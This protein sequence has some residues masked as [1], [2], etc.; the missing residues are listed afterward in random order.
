[1][2][3]IVITGA[4]L[5][6]PL[7][8]SLAEAREVFAQSRSVIS[9]SPISSPERPRVAAWVDADISVGLP[10]SLVKTADRAA[11]MALQASDRAVA[12]AGLTP[13]SFDA[14]RAGVFLGSAIG[15]IHSV[16]HAEEALFRRG[17][18]PAL[19][20]LK[21][22]PNGAASCVSM[23]HGFKGE[24]TTFA[25]ACAS[26]TTAFGAALRQLRLGELDVA[27]VGGAEAPLVE[28]CVLAWENL[29]MIARQDIE[30][31]ET[32]FR[33][34][35]ADRTGVV[36]GEGAAMYVLE[37]EEHARARGARILGVLQGFGASADAAHITAP[38]QEG[39]ALAM[40]KALQ[41]AGLGPSDIGYI[42]AHGTG[43][44]LG[45]ATETRSVIDVFGDHAQRV[46]MS[47]TKSA[48]GHLKGA[49]GAVE[50]AA[51]LVALND[52]IL[53]P[54]LN[55]N[56]ADPEC[57][58]DYVPNVARTGVRVDAVMSNAFAFGGS[59]CSMVVT[60]Y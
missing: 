42:N 24:C 30:H 41:N 20:L 53:P 37:T 27:L 56:E 44:K 17:N 22:L 46:P 6:S 45:D 19:T 34:F 50:L 9:V 32:C 59:N 14:T 49:S 52:G 25:V 18:M 43:T 54:T 1:M 39:Q 33:P 21:V 51:V 38:Q 13:G 47:S 8:W 35:A 36:L 29:R 60:R 28:S 7:G 40:R 57:M 12:D 2:R 55:L 3:K 48:H 4:G 15:T 58:L 23:R 10:G 26:A 5:C 11:V 31:P 16:Y